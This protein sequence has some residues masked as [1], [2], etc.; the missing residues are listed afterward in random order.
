MVGGVEISGALGGGGDEGENG[1]G[2]VEVGGAGA[3]AGALDES[4]CNADAV[5][6]ILDVD[7]AISS[8]RD[9]SPT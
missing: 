8:W 1:R 5:K 9:R 6:N 7:G 3:G 2:V 4:G